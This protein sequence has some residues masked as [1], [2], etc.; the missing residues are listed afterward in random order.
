MAENEGL[1]LSE[2]QL[3]VIN[4]SIVENIS[5]CIPEIIER[6]TPLIMEKIDTH[7]KQFWSH[8]KRNT[9]LSFTSIKQEAEHFIYS[10]SK[11]WS[12]LLQKRKDFVYKFTRCERLL[13]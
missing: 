11:L 2:E 13:D 7:L 4:R 9:E 6:V 3:N 12:D 1:F 8:D 10:N 5:K